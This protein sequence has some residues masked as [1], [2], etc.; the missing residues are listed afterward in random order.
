M[1]DN[2]HTLFNKLTEEELQLTVSYLRKGFLVRD[3]I[4]IALNELYGDLL[5]TVVEAV[6]VVDAAPTYKEA[7]L[8][9]WEEMKAECLANE[10]PPIPFSQPNH[11]GNKSSLVQ[12][13]EQMKGPW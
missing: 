6:E 12:S 10:A 1:D 9:T 13:I 3:A 11:F 7:L 8:E 4:G 2:L 5:H